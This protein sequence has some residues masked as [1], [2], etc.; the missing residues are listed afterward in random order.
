[1]IDVHNH[2]LFGI[3]D[4]AKT[5][6]DSIEIIK[7]AYKVGYKELILTPHFIEKSEYNCNNLGKITRFRSLQEYVKDFGIPVKLYL[8]NEVH[9]HDNI[10]ENIEEGNIMTLN[11]SKYLLLELPF[12]NRNYKV[13]EIIF[14][15]TRHDITPVIAHVERYRYM[16]EYDVSKM[17]ELGCLIQGNALSLIGKYG[18]EAEENLKKYLKMNLIHVL[19][20]DAHNTKAFKELKDIKKVVKKIVKNDDMVEDLF[21][22]NPKKMIEDETIIPY[23]IKRKKQFSFFR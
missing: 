14:E 22:L 16:T 5:L 17:I 11:A 9:I 18:R 6:E 2:I 15:L 12:R 23:Q 7:E 10:I 4:G 20:S 8:G 19:A 21:K 3:D 13:E 1:M